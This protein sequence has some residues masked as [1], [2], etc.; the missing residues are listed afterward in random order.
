MAKPGPAPTPSHLRIVRGD[1]KDRI[2][3]NEPKPK[4]AKPKCPSWLSKEAKAVW[5]RTSAQLDAM[6]L[7]FEADQD[8]LAAYSVAVVTYQQATKLV[9]EQGVLVEGRRD[10]WVT[11]P[12]VRVQRDQATLIRMLAS[13]MGLTPSSRTRLKAEESSDEEDNFLD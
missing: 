9:E 13:E 3:T 8:I 6:G 4:K 2:N 12:A 7:L 10:G 1:R 5:R 11:N